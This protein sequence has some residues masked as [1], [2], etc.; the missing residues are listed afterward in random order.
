MDYIIKNIA[1]RLNI[2]PI[3]ILQGVKHIA[4]CQHNRSRYICLPF[5]L[6]GDKITKHRQHHVSRF[7]ILR[8]PFTWR[9]SNID[10]N[11]LTYGADLQRI[12]HEQ[13]P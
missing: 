9:I 5:I 2:L 11:F 4:L 10:S 13:Q 12:D 7:I 8:H 6:I 1:I 3:L